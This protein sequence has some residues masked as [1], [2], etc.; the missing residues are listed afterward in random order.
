MPAPV[1]FD[2]ILQKKRF[3]QFQLTFEALL[4]I[5]FITFY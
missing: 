1:I 4:G 3:L 2:K 5:I